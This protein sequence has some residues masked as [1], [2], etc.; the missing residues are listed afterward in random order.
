MSKFNT[1]IDYNQMLSDCYQT[2][3]N[4]K[5]CFSRSSNKSLTHFKQN[6][7]SFLVIA[8]HI[9]NNLTISC[10]FEKEGVN[11]TFPY[12][13][14]SKLQ[15]GYVDSVLRSYIYTVC[16]VYVANIT[17]YRNIDVRFNVNISMRRKCIHQCY[18]CWLGL[19]ISIN[20]CT[21]DLFHDYSCTFSWD[22]KAS[23]AVQYGPYFK[24]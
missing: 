8:C 21:V 10:Y 20:V 22:Q 15:W 18:L 1:T 17:L 14:I 23:W 9:F 16:N 4:W 11:D 3:T 12:E 5:P 13:L 6:D 7:W 19:M 24:T 2:W